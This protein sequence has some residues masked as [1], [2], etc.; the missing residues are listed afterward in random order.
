MII[1]TLFREENKPELGVLIWNG[2]NLFAIL[3]ENN[4]PVDIFEEKCNCLE[5]ALNVATHHFEQVENN[6]KEIET[7]EDRRCQ[8]SNSCRAWK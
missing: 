8:L 6:L 2:E 7:D 4:N 5:N 3:D 1:E